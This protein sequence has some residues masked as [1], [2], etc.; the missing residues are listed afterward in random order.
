MIAEHYLRS[1]VVAVMA[2]GLVLPVTVQAATTPWRS[3]DIPLLN[4]PHNLSTYRGSYVGK[5]IYTSTTEGRV[6]IFCHTPHHVAIDPLDGGPVAPLWSR[7]LSTAVYI[8]YNSPTIKNAPDQPTGSSRLCLSCHDG[9]IALGVL[10]GVY[11]KYLL[12]AALGK[13]VAQYPSD[14]T[15][16]DTLIGTDLSTSHPIS[17]TYVNDGVSEYNNPATV[18]SKGAVKLVSFASDYIVECTS[19][20]DPHNNGAGNFLVMD[21]VN[22]TPL[23][24]ECHNKSGWNSTASH[25]SGGT[26]NGAEAARV[27]S[28]GCANC[29]KSHHSSGVN[30][31]KDVTGYKNCT[32][33]CH[34]G[35]S[36]RVDIAAAIDPTRV[37]SRHPMSATTGHAVNEVLPARD[38]HVECS[39]C[40][41]P[42]WAGYTAPA[43]RLPAPAASAAL[44]GVRG[45]DM[46]LGEVNPAPYEYQ[47]CYRCHAGSASTYVVNFLSTLSRPAR[48][49]TDY[50]EQNRFNSTISRHPVSATRLYA[51]GSTVYQS[52]NASYQNSNQIFCTDCHDPHGSAGYPMLFK[53]AYAYDSLNDVSA[54]YDLCAICHNVPGFVLTTNSGFTAGGVKS[55]HGVHCTTNHLSCSACHDPHGISTSAGGVNTPS[56]NHGHL[57]N[58]DTKVAGSNAKYDVSG[59]SGFRTC[60]NLAAGCHATGSHVY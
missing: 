22:G 23:C 11:R 12:D 30:L 25:K 54:R 33:T 14:P 1:I 36:Y 46:A 35:S 47:I 40:H 38:K 6:C 9:T 51:A 13:M 26:F 50:R 20:H 32:I 42:H 31:L 28:S 8:P 56:D 45:V 48:V 10:N 55:L 53:G 21:N 3:G 16:P 43:S 27:A 37:V 59:G 41:N 15:G 52:L 57:I 39:D 44:S 24:L 18:A 19:C 58:F 17:M 49:I 5:S 2:I 29:H 60:S 4:T 7:D 34:T